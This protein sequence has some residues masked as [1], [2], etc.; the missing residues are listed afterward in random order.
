[1]QDSGYQGTDGIGYRSMNQPF[2]RPAFVKAVG[3][4]FF[5]TGTYSAEDISLGNYEMTLGQ[6][7]FAV[8]KV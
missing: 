6:M 3:E 2:D 5:G 7:A 1:M 4:S 8:Y